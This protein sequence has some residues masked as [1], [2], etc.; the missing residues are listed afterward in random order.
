M[1]R[2]NNRCQKDGITP[3]L[4]TPVQSNLLDIL[5]GNV[6]ICVCWLHPQT[7]DICDCHQHVENVGPTRWR[8]YVKLAFFFADVA[9]ISTSTSTS[10]Y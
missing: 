7:T 8:H 3:S 6:R 4:R 2:L 1:T 5:A 10:R 9:N